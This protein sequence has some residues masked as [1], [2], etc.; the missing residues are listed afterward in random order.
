MLEKTWIV[1]KCLALSFDL[2]MSLMFGDSIV[3]FIGTLEYPMYV[4]GSLK[5]I[6]NSMIQIIA[7]VRVDN[8]S[9]GSNKVRSSMFDRSKPKIGCLSSII[10]R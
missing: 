5:C 9:D 4:D 1:R 2:S 10:K 3:S 7:K 8:T 6:T